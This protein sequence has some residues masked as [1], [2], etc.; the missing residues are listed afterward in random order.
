MLKIFVYSSTYFNF[1]YR[2][3]EWEILYWYKKIIIIGETNAECDVSIPEY[4]PAKSYK[5]VI[6]FLLRFYY[7]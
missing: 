3:L 2:V 5:L 7:F 4:D 1:T 6:Y